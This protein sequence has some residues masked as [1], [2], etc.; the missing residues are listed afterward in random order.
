MKKNISIKSWQCNFRERYPGL[1]RA[2]MI[3][4]AMQAIRRHYWHKI[5][6]ERA[7]KFSPFKNPLVSIYQRF[8]LRR[9][10]YAFGERCHNGMNRRGGE[11][12]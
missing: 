4:R 6:P 3:Q 12:K 10:C 8:V 1:R 5:A 11:S 7:A 2:V 9:G